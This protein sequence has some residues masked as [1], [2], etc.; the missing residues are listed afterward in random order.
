M[1]GVQTCAL[2]ICI[3]EAKQANAN[4]KLNNA[5][6][7][8]LLEVIT[9]LEDKFKSDIQLNEIK[10]SAMVNIMDSLEQIKTSIHT[11]KQ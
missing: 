11:A 10:S 2:P 1:T 3:Y 4:W 6:R 7:N 9:P 5:I 8:H